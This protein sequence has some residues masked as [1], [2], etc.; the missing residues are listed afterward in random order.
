MVMSFKQ[1]CGPLDS[2]S[3]ILTVSF[4]G[5]LA[6][7]SNTGKHLLENFLPYWVGMFQQSVD[8]YAN[9]SFAYIIEHIIFIRTFL[10]HVIPLN[11]ASANG[12]IRFLPVDKF[13]FFW[14]GEKGISLVILCFPAPQDPLLKPGS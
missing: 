11:R 5:P 8:V 14:G 10:I 9:R 2:G 13:F 4:V 12:S 1:A 3:K 7:S 6:T